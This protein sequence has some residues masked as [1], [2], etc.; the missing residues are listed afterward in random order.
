[1]LTTLFALAAVVLGAT[2]IRRPRNRWQR[3]AAALAAFLMLA[4]IV[5]WGVEYVARSAK[6]AESAPAH[7]LM[8]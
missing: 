1:M 7:R 8:L 6:A 4:V 5:A 3:I 2:L